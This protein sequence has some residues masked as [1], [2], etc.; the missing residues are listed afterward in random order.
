MIIDIHGVL[1]FPTIIMLPLISFFMSANICLMYKGAPMLGTYI[2]MKFDV[3]ISQ[4]CL[5]LCDPMD[6]TVHGILQARILEGVAFPFS[7][8]SSQPEDQS[9]VS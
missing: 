4:S 3:K 5:A 1:K 6:Y 2:F 9:Q 8:G 7:R